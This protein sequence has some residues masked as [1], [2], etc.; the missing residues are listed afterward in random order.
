MYLGANTPAREISAAVVRRGAMAV[1]LSMA[2]PTGGPETVEELRALRRGLPPG[3]SVFV[4]GAAAAS[5]AT[6]LREIAAVRLD[7]LGGLRTELGRLAAG[8]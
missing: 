8:G 6:V 4:G 3:V 7:D 1:A 2:H 5:C